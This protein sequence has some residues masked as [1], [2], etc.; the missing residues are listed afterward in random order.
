M[1]AAEDPETKEQKGL[2]CLYANENHFCFIKQITHIHKGTF[3]FARDF[4]QLL[5]NALL[6]YGTNINILILQTKQLRPRMPLTPNYLVNK[7]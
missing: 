1:R 5:I 2:K 7:Y 4:L 3:L 6:G